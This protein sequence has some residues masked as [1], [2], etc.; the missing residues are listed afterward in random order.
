[1]IRVL[2]LKVTANQIRPAFI[3]INKINETKPPIVEIIFTPFTPAKLIIIKA[4]APMIP[5]QIIFNQTG[6]FSAKNPKP[7]VLKA[8]IASVFESAAVTNDMNMV[9]T[10]IIDTRLWKGMSC[11][12]L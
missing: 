9:M 5:P 6:D 1:M 7:R 11:N 12:N 8:L 2:L 3:T 10:K 4:V